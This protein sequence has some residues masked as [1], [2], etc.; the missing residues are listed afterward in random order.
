MRSAG[1]HL[2]GMTNIPE[3]FLARE[4]QICYATVGIVTDYDCWMDDPAKHVSVSAIF[5][6]YGKSLTKARQLIDALLATPL[7]PEEPE[8]RGALRSALMTPEAALSPQQRDWL[9]VLQR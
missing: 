4:A 7:P 9:S 6:L 3:A 5:E 8:I 1:C 2:V